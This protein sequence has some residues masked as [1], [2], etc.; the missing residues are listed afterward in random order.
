MFYD[1]ILIDSS[2][3][4]N[5]FTDI[6]F[7]LKR[8]ILLKLPNGNLKVNFVGEVITPNAKIISLRKKF[9]INQSNINLTVDVLKTFRSLT[10][11][12]KSLIENKSFT[13][14]DEITSDVQY[15]KILKNFFFDHITYDFIT[16]KNKI[17]KHTSVPIA[18]TFDVV[19]TEINSERIGPGLTYKLKD[20]TNLNWRGISLS[21]IYYSTCK[22]LFEEFGTKE[23]KDEF[24][25]IENYYKSKGHNFEYINIDEEFVIN[26]I[27]KN[28]VGVVHLT[29]KSNLT[30][31]YKNKSV[32]EKYK[33][34]IFYSKNFEYVWE[35]FCRIV[36]NHNEK[37]KRKIDWIESSYKSSN[38]DVFSD[39][40]ENMFIADCKYYNDIN[41]DY[42]KEMYEY[43]ECQNNKY[44]IVILVPSDETIIFN[45]PRR[46]N[47][48]ELLIIKISLEEVIK[49]VIDGRN[50]V[51]NKIYSI[52]ENKSIR[53]LHNK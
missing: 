35:H 11:D 53:K 49:D 7:L 48:I 31:Y 5:D 47:D 50:E 19:Q 43:N 27:S 13:S 3:V 22:D 20:K 45:E 46:H 41:S 38:P 8:E 14:G 33:I 16:P 1:K 9:K 44:P 34:R 4:E 29:I 28:E 23:D 52:I 24:I 15:F 42:T 21:N 2:E 30:N 51:L 36:L 40:N 32:N 17:N 39:F 37:F 25:F 18:A 6:D 10:K 12:G 26:E